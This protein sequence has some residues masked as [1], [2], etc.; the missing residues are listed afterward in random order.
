[1]AARLEQ[2]AKERKKR[3]DALEMWFHRRMLKIPWTAKRSNES[4]LSKLGKTLT[5]T[6][7]IR[8]HQAKIFGHVMRRYGLE[9]LITTT[10][11]NRKKIQGPTE[12][13]DSG[14]HEEMDRGRESRGLHHQIGRQ[15]FVARNGLQRQSAR[16][17]TLSRLTLTRIVRDYLNIHAISHQLFLS[18]DGNILMVI[19]V[20]Q[21]VKLFHLL[22]T[23]EGKVENLSMAK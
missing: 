19:I 20:I 23:G 16:N 1:M 7:K 5:L 13:K 10:K 15:R 11:V 6:N 12:R 2:S 14:L 9:H 17:Y 3:I 21:M 22:A 8:S 18:F 4:I